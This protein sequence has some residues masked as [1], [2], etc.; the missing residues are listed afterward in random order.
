M[1]NESSEPSEPPAGPEPASTDSDTPESDAPAPSEPPRAAEPAPRSKPSRAPL[2]RRIVEWFWRGA[3]I[4][5]AGKLADDDRTATRSVLELA[6]QRGEAAETLWTT[7]HLVE[8]LRLAAE[9]LEVALELATAEEALRPFGASPRDIERV[10]AGRKALGEPRPER[11]SE[12][13]DIHTERYLAIQ[14]ARRTIGALHGDRIATKGTLRLQRLQ[15]IGGVLMGVTA[16]AVVLWLVM[17]T[18]PRTEVRASGQFPGAQY[19][20]AN[21]FDGNESTEW[22]LPDGETGWVEGRIFPAQD[23]ESLRILNGRNSRFGDRAV[24]EY[25]VQ[26]FRGGEMLGE[27][28]SVFGTIEQSPEWVEVPLSGAGVTRIRF[29]ALGFHRRGPALAEIAWD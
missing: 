11:D 19:A 20:P 1:S 17:R 21:A 24:K 16:V 29:E 5:R 25:K 15:R 18:P 28:E 27:H 2:G 12:I 26:L 23:I 4:G 14:G 8:A 22:V 9:A 13:E 6:D 7:G 3:A 10:A